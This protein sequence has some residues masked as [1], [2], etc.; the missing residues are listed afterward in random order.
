[1]RESEYMMETA[2]DHRKKFGQFF[3]PEPVAR[4]MARWAVSNN[5]KT[6]LDPAFGLGVF[7]DQ[8]SAVYPRQ[9]LNFTA[10]EIDDN[11]LKF[12]RNGV[13]QKEPNIITGDYLTTNGESFDSIICNPPYLRFQNFL[14][15]HHVLPI[16]ERGLNIKLNG[17]TNIASIFLI[18][19]LNQLNKNGNLAFVMPFEF[20]N[21]GYGE[22]IKKYLIENNLL[23]Y[24]IIFSNEKEIFSEVTTTICVL[25]CRNDNIRSNIKVLKVA[26]AAILN[27]IGEIS[28]IDSHE[29]TPSELNY[30]QKW[31][32]IINVLFNKSE[33]MQLSCK[34]SF[35]GKVMR[36]IATGANDFFSFTQSKM[37]DLGID[38]CNFIKCITKSNQLK[39]PVFEERDYTSLCNNDKA[40]LCLD[41]KQKN[42]PRVIKYLQYGESLKYNERYLTKL[43]NPWYKLE[44]RSPAPI[45]I[46]VFN[47]GR[48]KV[49]RN[50]TDAVNFTCYHSFYPNLFGSG[51][52]NK[53]FLYL[54]SD[55][56]QDFIRLNMRTYGAGLEKVEPNDLNTV[57]CP[58]QEQFDSIKSKDVDNIIA[59][60]NRDSQ[61]AI[62]HSNELFASAHFEKK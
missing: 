12:Y 45:L 22:S 29:I 20:F 26:S 13:G 21:T 56:G 14:N 58:T 47:R 1:M 31:T 4:L 28:D 18:K 27:K 6:I 39:S 24:I 44:S 32:P 59:M 60:A 46:G 9:D 10:Y 23:K 41:V 49:I 42:N 25:L 36:G 11:I 3:T 38:R 53:I 62:E 43:R 5:P 57:Y 7:H 52:V 55:F 50:F 8:V 37:N 54:L 33:K 19:A 48:V 51:Y 35:Y 16:I 15:R 61:K 34:L 17:Y 40:V 2:L 30:K